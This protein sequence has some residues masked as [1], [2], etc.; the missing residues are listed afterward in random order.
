MRFDELAPGDLFRVELWH[1]LPPLQRGSS[2]GRDMGMVTWVK[3]DGTGYALHRWDDRAWT[4]LEDP[5]EQY[6][7]AVLRTWGGGMRVWQV[8][9][10][11][12]G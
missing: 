7:G 8:D 4:T 10:E 6:R 1:E 9:G 12:D 11:G 2:A 5:R 3:V